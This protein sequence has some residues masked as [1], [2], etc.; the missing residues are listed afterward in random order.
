MEMEH[1]GND[2]PAPASGPGAGAAGAAVVLFV[3]TTTAYI[4]SGTSL[5]VA[6]ITFVVLGGLG[7]LFNAAYDRYVL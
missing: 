2:G 4:V 6:A 3:C 1:L 7:L 5:R